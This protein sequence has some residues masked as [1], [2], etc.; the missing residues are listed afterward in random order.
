MSFRRCGTQ[1]P[2]KGSFLLAYFSMAISSLG[3]FS[4]FH[5]DFITHQDRHMKDLGEEMRLMVDLDAERGQQSR[6]SNTFRVAIKRTARVNLAQL[7]AYLDGKAPMDEAVISAITFLD[8]LL[9]ETPSK[10]AI[11]IRRSYFARMG[12]DRAQLG[13]GVEAMKGVY[14][15]MRV[16]QV[17]DS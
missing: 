4:T 9:R 7:Q 8:H 5:A 2:C 15:S 6:D 1:R 16:A 14:Q 3:M 12:A 10:S 11:N 17:R 13:Q